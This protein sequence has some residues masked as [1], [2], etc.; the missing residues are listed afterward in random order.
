MLYFFC[1]GLDNLLGKYMSKTVTISMCDSDQFN[2]IFVCQF[3]F[4]VDSFVYTNVI[5]LFLGC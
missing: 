1:K 5:T 2:L 3:F 4:F